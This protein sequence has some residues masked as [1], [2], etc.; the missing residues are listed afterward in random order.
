MRVFGKVA[1]IFAGTIDVIFPYVTYRDNEEIGIKRLRLAQTCVR[2]KEADLNLF[3]SSELEEA[4][5]P[6]HAQKDNR[7]LRGSQLIAQSMLS[8]KRA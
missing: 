7:R 2:R 6:E 8:I 5:R 4:M 3:R 1:Y